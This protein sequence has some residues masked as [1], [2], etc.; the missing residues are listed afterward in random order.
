MFSQ[1][2]YDPSVLCSGSLS[3]A[4]S[5]RLLFGVPQEGS[6]QARHLNALISEETSP[7]SARSLAHLTVTACQ[8]DNGVIYEASIPTQ[9]AGHAAQRYEKNNN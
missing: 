8:Q 9:L 7:L 5:I 6:L 1:A 3:F 2:F 4:E